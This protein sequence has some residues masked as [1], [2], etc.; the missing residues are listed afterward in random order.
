VVAHEA[1][2][3][4]ENL[5]LRCERGRNR[6]EPL[7]VD[8]GEDFSAGVPVGSEVIDPT[9]HPDTRL[10][11]RSNVGPLPAHRNRQFGACS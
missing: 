1:V 11:H 2:A 5:V 10:T 4:D 3:D 7:P 8:V 6:K 9:G